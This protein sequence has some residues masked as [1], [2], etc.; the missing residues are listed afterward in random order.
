MIRVPN[1]E[2]KQH[3]G[4]PNILDSELG[5]KSPSEH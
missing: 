1:S 5:N 4:D 3:E 2:L